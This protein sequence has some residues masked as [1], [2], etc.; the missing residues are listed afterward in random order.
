MNFD[1]REWIGHKIGRM[2]AMGITAV[3]VFTLF[4]AVLVYFTQYLWNWL[5]PT[6][7][8]GPVLGYWQMMG[9]LV[10]LKI[11]LWPVSGGRRWG[12]HK[13]W[14]PRWDQL[15]PEERERLKSRMRE[16]WC[17]PATSVPPAT[18]DTPAQP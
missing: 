2:I 6:I 10:L 14:G 17:P 1:K 8:G 12:Q 16:K 18:G 5:V 7:F 11:L 13:G 9:L 15:S 3:I 4:F